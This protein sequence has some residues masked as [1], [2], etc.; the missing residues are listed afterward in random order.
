MQI[1][2]SIK[3][4]YLRL[5][6]IQQTETPIPEAEP[7]VE[8]DAI[9]GKLALVY[10]KIRNT[11]D[12][13]EDHLLRRFAIER[14]LKRRIILESL[15]PKISR[16][17][18]EELIRSG[19][20]KNN[21]VPES[22]VPTIS[23]IL[24]KYSYLVDLVSEGV[25]DGSLRRK[26]LDWIAGICACEIDLLFTPELRSDA[27]IETL[28]AII[29]DRI[30]LAGGDLS[31]REKN[32]QLYITLHMELVKSDHPIIAYHLFNL[33]FPDWKKADKRL[34]EYVASKIT[35]VYH[36]IQ[37]HINNPVR[38]KLGKSLKKP[39]VV[40]K[41]LKELINRNN[42]D[43]VKLFGEPEYLETEARI[44]V[45]KL[46][47]SIRKK[48]RRS[49]VRAIIYIFI[50]KVLL[51]FLLEYPYDLLTLGYVNYVPLFINIIF[52]PMLMFFVTLSARIPGQQNTKVIVAEI[53]KLVYGEPENEILCRLKVP[54]KQGP[55]YYFFEYL[56]YVSLYAFIF[57]I[58]SYLLGRLSFNLLSGAIFLFFIT[59]VSFFGSRIRQITREYDVMKSKEGV[60]SYIFTFLS[61]P[62]VRV[63]QWFSV[64]MRRINLF[65]FIFDFIIEAPFKLLIESIEG[66]FA[67]LREK[68]DEVYKN[69]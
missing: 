5:I 18:V 52:P 2:D 40:F 63:G 28:Y 23:T 62:I 47:H 27:L 21:E 35:S 65:V 38:L 55:V 13:Q 32:I 44:V 29:R 45:E 11:M 69:T 67:F 64:N 37:E 41:V 14:N 39:I 16:Q 46:N 60:M 24:N 56:F 22:V 36:G 49:S 33:Y 51:A 58:I 7:R 31:S 30:K 9:I 4:L 12:Y 50:T 25:D 15:S 34:V 68:K 19:Y 20:L 61:L 43:L 48:L 54:R 26:I 10:E 17:I 53:K 57:G 66:W 59:A 8:V 6:A 1:S 3:D 42:D